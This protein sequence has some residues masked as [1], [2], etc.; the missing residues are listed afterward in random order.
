MEPQKNVK[1]YE[2]QLLHSITVTI[3]KIEVKCLQNNTVN[4]LEK[5]RTAVCH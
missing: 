5:I 1:I 2:S 3:N 4:A